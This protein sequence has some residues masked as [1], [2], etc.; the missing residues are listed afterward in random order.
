MVKF[1]LYFAHNFKFS[2]IYGHFA[3]NYVEKRFMEQA[4]AIRIGEILPLWQIFKI[5]WKFF[6][7]LIIIWQTFEQSVE[8]FQKFH[9]EWANFIAAIGQI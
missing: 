5:L 7:C 6:E 9:C 1:W 8:K 3:I 4:P 2:V